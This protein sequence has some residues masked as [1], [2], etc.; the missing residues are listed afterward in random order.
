MVVAVRVQPV[1]AIPVS[2]VF[3]WMRNVVG[4]GVMPVL[5]KAVPSIIIILPAALLSVVVPGLRAGTVLDTSTAEVCF[6]TK[7]TENKNEISE[8]RNMMKM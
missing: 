3:L 8:A 1:T 6:A 7:R 5:V 2:G 4:P